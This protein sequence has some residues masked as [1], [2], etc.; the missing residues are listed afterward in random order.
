MQWSDLE[1]LLAED[2]GELHAS[3]MASLQ[4][5]EGFGK[6]DGHRVKWIADNIVPLLIK[7][8]PTILALL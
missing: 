8:G 5:G 6:P 3:Y 2:G 1:Q 4:S 7:Y